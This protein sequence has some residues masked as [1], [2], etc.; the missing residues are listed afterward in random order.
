[1]ESEEKRKR[2][3][4]KALE[5]GEKSGFS[6]SFDVKKHLEKIHQESL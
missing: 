3:L 4:I 5:M 1:L 6:E 2:E